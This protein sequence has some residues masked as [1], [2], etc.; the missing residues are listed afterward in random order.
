VSD[1]YD[2]FDDSADFLDDVDD[3]PNCGGEGVIYHCI[4]GC[5]VDA[6]IGCE[7]C[8]RTCDLCRPALSAKGGVTP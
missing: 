1:P 4:D 8:E 3:C 7:L 2:D 5:C 6:D